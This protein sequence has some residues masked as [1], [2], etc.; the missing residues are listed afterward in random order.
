MSGQV[1]FTPTR[2]LNSSES[3]TSAKINDA[4][5]GEWRIGEDEIGN[6]ELSEHIRDGFAPEAIIE[7][8]WSSATNG[9]RGRD[10]F[11]IDMSVDRV[12]DLNGSDLYFT[13]DSDNIGAV[14]T[15]RRL[16]GDGSLRVR[17]GDGESPPSKKILSVNGSTI[18]TSGANQGMEIEGDVRVTQLM[19]VGNGNSLGLQDSSI[20]WIEVYRGSLENQ[21]VEEVEEVDLPGQPGKPNRTLS[22]ESTIGAIWTRPVDGGDIEFYN[23]QISTDPTFQMVDQDQS[24]SQTSILF[25]NLTSDTSYYI[26]VRGENGSG[27]GEWSETLLASTEFPEENPEGIV[28]P[29]NP[30]RPR[31]TRRTFSLLGASTTAPTSGGDVARYRWRI[32]KSVAEL[33][34]A[35]ETTTVDRTETFVDLDS[36]TDY[37][38]SVRAENAGGESEWVTSAALTTDH[39]PPGNPGV[40]T[41]SGNDITHSS[42]KGTT[43]APT[44]G[45]PP[46][47]YIWRIAKTIGGLDGASN[48]NSTSLT[49]TFSSLDADTVY[50][51]GVRSA[52]LGGESPRVD[53]AAIRT[54][55]EPIGPPGVPGKPA[56]SSKTRTS[57]TATTTTPTD[58]G[59]VVN[60]RW[61]IAKTISALATASTT[62]TTGR[63]ETFSGLT[64]NTVYYVSVRAEN[65]G[66]NSVYINS[67]AIRTNDNPPGSPSKP[68]ASSK[69]DTT[70]TASTSAPSSGGAT[71]GY[72]WRI[73]KTVGGLATASPTTSAGR[74]QTFTGLDSDTIYYVSVRA[75]NNGGSS[76]YVNSAAIR[77]NETAPGNP[78]TP[79]ATKTHNTIT[80]TTTAP[81]SGNAVDLYRWRIAT[82]IAGLATAPTIT[83]TG[84]SRTFTRL[85]GSTTYYVS[86]RAENTGGNSQYVN[87]ASITTSVSPITAPGSPGKPTASSKTYSTI[88]ATT[89]AP[90]TGDAVDN[91]RWRIATT[92]GGLSSATTVTTAGR[93]N[94]FTGLDSDTRYFVSVRA[95][96]NGGESSYVNSSGIRTDEEAPSDPGRPVVTSQTD[97]SISART[98]APA[99]G[100]P[101]DLY[102]WRIAT[103]IDGLLSA[104][105][106]TSTGLTHIFTGLDSDTTYYVSVRAEN[107]GGNSGYVNSAAAKT[108]KE[109]PGKPGKPTLARR[110]QSSIT[111]ETTAPTSGDPVERYRWIRVGTAGTTTTTTLSNRFT[112][113]D[114]DTVYT[115]SVRAENAGGN[116]AYVTSDDIRTSI[117]PP[118]A[119]G[120]PTISSR[121]TDSI[122]MKT[123]APTSGGAV[124]GYQWRI[125]TTPTR[126]ANTGSSTNFSLEYTFDSLRADTTYYVDVR[127]WNGGGASAWVESKAVSTTEDAPGKPGIPVLHLKT[128]TAITVT[129]TAPTTG[130]DVDLYRW[131]ISKLLSGLASASTT[132]TV[133]T[134]RTFAGLDPS[135][136]YYTAVRAENKGGN[137]G[138]ATSEAIRTDGVPLPKPNI[139]GS[140]VFSSITK[141]SFRA[142]TSAPTGGGEVTNYRYQIRETAGTDDDDF[143]TDRN[144][145]TPEG[146]VLWSGLKTGTNY[147]VR[148]RAENTTGN[149]DWR[150]ATVDTEA[151]N[152]PGVPGTPVG[153]R[154]ESDDDYDY[155]FVTTAPTSGGDPTKYRWSIQRLQGLFWVDVALRTTTRLSYTFYGPDLVGSATAVRARV[156][157]ENDDGESNYSAYS[158]QVST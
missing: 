38:V 85:K 14:I 129:T 61:R 59:A 142:R 49:Q 4:T 106:D 79:T 146:S 118:G 77:T 105:T 140:I 42:I 127:A 137:S 58:G 41:S 135:T 12:V 143:G 156:R 11:P 13:N 5:S 15:F 93:T 133:G 151:L 23:A 104:S 57:I 157:A 30:G 36:N 125:E 153:S 20:R 53:S 26:R 94:T 92:T 50:Y 86:V 145:A 119:P 69:T 1:S 131:K 115:F 16:S 91:Y 54:L 62:T 31:A 39:E 88:T 9:L 81:T 74:S 32:A 44:T 99:T 101:V 35:I 24:S 98:T 8:D 46:S 64:A 121:T 55:P 109:A 76:S 102:R 29:G 111:V 117:E 6:R 21:F 89:T 122:T 10:V 138:Y 103:T 120:T 3:I 123:T 84:R 28:A 2:A 66:G 96:N 68:T 95:E 75:E 19:Y 114:T 72:R 110:T 45:G 97:S 33:V 130:G 100:D 73:A 25:Q 90:T 34:S 48:V 158:N 83:T 148:V 63:S 136:N 107:T 52:N 18:Y 139:P 47:A 7:E 108:D 144:S 134:T 37:Y 71:T 67:S 70:I 124:T 149:S 43:T 154:R 65:T 113:L 126:L 152:P 17:V 27:T 132:T 60:Y 80:A 147:S 78:G 116:S 56:T 150:T 112:G 40:P 82:S 87:S 22:T 51:I 141:T 128:S 155:I